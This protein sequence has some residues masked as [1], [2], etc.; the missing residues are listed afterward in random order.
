MYN[1]H[2]TANDILQRGEC[3]FKCYSRVLKGHADDFIE[4]LQCS[5]IIENLYSDAW[6]QMKHISDMHIR[7]LRISYLT[8][9]FQ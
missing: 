2:L 7:L 9:L 6:K 4:K 8:A 1:K 3:G 5:N